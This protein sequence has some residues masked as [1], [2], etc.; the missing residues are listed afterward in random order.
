MMWNP[1]VNIHTGETNMLRVQTHIRQIG[2]DM[3]M[4]NPRQAGLYYDEIPPEPFLNN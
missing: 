1:N 3:K 2:W 4:K